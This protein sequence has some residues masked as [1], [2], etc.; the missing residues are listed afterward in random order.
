MNGKDRGSLL[1]AMLLVA[2]TCIGGG[3]LALPVATGSLGFFPSLV[4]MAVC[5]LA[6]TLTGLLLVEATLWMK[7]GAHIVS[8]SR[9]LLG[10]GGEV[11]SVLVYLFICYASLVA[12]ASGGGSLLASV[13]ERLSGLEVTKSMGCVVFTLL[14]SG[15]VYLGSLVVGR[16]NAIMVVAMMGAYVGLVALGFPEVKEHLLTR[17]HW[18]ESF[19]AIPLLLTSFSFQTMVPSLIPDLR[20]HPRQLKLAIVGGTSL[21]FVVYVLWQLVVL[22]I[23]PVEGPQ[24]LQAAMAQGEPATRALGAMVHSPWVHYFSEYFAFFAIVTSFLGIGLGLFDFLADGSGLPKRG[25]GSLALIVLVIVPTL[26]F[27]LFYERAFITA[28]ETSGGLGDTVLNGIMPALMVWLGRYRLGFV[29]PK[30]VPGGRAVL[31][32]IVL[33]FASS[34]VYELSRHLVTAY[35]YSIGTLDF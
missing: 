5:W 17:H 8:I 3:M 19:S 12:Y 14:F 11:F 29:G 13:A 33:F 26:A 31:L 30:A 22:G 20:H 18:N 32:F 21:S 24:G 7:E 4:M 2:G 23:V 15:A 6:M 34:L 35:T 25:W 10:R 1:A 9:S 27:A 28:L 16:V